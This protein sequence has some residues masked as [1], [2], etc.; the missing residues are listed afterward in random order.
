M[1]TRQ[2]L[3][4]SHPAPINHP[5]D[6]TCTEPASLAGAF[7]EFTAAAGR[8]ENSY[9]ALQEEV[10][11]LRA[12]LAERNRALRESRAE[13]SQMKLALRQILDSLPCGVMV[14]E[15]GQRVALSNPEARRLL[16]V[17]PERLARLDEIPELSL[18]PLL[19]I[20]GTSP[21]GNTEQEFC[22]GGQ[23]GKRWLAV[24]SC[25][26]NAAATAGRGRQTIVILRETTHQKNLE[27]EREAARNAVALAEMSAVLAHEIRNPLASLELFAG[28][29][30]NRGEDGGAYV[31]QLRAG[32]RSLSATVNNVLRLHSGGTV[33]RTR[34]ALLAS[35]REAAEFARP[36]AEQHAIDLSLPS[37][38]DEMVIGGDHNALQ[39]VFLNLAVNAFRHTPRGGRLRIKADLVTRAGSDWARV[40]FSDNGCGIDP[41]A[42]P[43]IFGAGFSGGGQT[44]GLGLAVCRRIVEQH[45][46]SIGATS[47]VGRGATLFLEFPI[48][49]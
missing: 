31:S 30:S 10:V 3:P 16:E 34:M 23:A 1:G 13:N 29:I 46:G 43:H 35:L 32:I 9:G 20:L 25:E 26:L 14:L 38:S 15:E 40:E 24:R 7:A 2:M 48:L 6:G 19:S 21:S 22:A 27:E 44:P 42:L 5:A 33:Q 41:E 47:E 4:T 39:Q 36:L 12:V 45:D 28:L 17:Q 49:S 18:R 8:L 37:E 11:Q